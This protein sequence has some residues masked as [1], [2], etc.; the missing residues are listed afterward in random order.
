MQIKAH[1]WRPLRLLLVF[2]IL[3][4]Y[5]VAVLWLYRECSVVSTVAA[6][7]DPTTVTT[8]A[9]PTASSAM[10]LI[11]IL[12][13]VLLLWPDVSEVTV[14]GVTLKR[15]VEEAKAD[16]AAAKQEAATLGQLVQSLQVQLNSVIS[17]AAAASASINQSIF[18]PDYPWNDRQSD[19]VRQSVDDL[20]REF[21]EQRKASAEP[22]GT[23]SRTYSS[24]LASFE[25]LSDDSLKM[26]LIHEWEEFNSILGIQGLNRSR[27][28]D[29]LSEEELRTR[30]AQKRF[31]AAHRETIAGVRSLRNAVAHGK[32]V[33]R[34]DVM[35]GLQ[36][37]SLLF[38]L[39]TEW[40][41]HA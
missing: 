25:S 13:A 35:E 10:V 36:A 38:P 23:K 19:K 39:A 12:L 15:K 21:D 33:Q 9:P 17:T 2:L 29:Q 14:L 20:R 28:E 26:R 37:L 8:C 30:Q 41:E 1:S 22:A 5:S 32:N 34:D 16:A 18:L 27:H 11:L 3:I 24:D 40:L 6:N 4:A 7:T 31:V